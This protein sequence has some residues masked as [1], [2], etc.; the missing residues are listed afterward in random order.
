MSDSLTKK[1]EVITSAARLSAS[2]Q[3]LGFAPPPHDRFAIS[4]YQNFQAILHKAV[5]LSMEKRFDWT[6]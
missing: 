4:G 2:L 5:S 3:I 6:A 1:T